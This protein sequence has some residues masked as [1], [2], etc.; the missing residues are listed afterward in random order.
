MQAAEASTPQ[1]TYGTFIIS[2]R[3]WMVPSSPYG[4]C[5][6]GNT[7]S[8]WPREVS[9]P[10]ASRAK[11]PSWPRATSSTTSLAVSVF[12]TIGMPSLMF[13]PRG[14]SPSTIHWPVLVMPTGIAS[15]F[16]TSSARSTPAVE[17]HEIECSSALPPYITT[18][19]FLAM[20]RPLTSLCVYH[21]S[22]LFAAYSVF[23][24]F[25]DAFIEEFGEHLGAGD[26]VGEH[27]AHGGGER[28]ATPYC[29]PKAT[30]ASVVGTPS[31][32]PLLTLVASSTLRPLPRLE[33][34]V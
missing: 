25:A 10:S 8:T 21:T 33:P 5:N 16:S 15:N 30:T 24:L 23:L 28:V 20:F 2:N 27:V 11:K 12:L 6:T 31:A 3:P 9:V 1:P 19:R 17:M 22:I 14:S 32:T 7:A 18:M 26:A 4:P 29:L 34:N 13:Q